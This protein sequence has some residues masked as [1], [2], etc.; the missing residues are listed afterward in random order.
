MFRVLRVDSD[1]TG[2]RCWVEEYQRAFSFAPSHFGAEQAIV[3]R[4]L[5]VYVVFTMRGA[6]LEPPQEP[7]ERRRPTLP[8][9]A[10]ER[11]RETSGER[12]RESKGAA[13]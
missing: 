11:Q 1:F 10:A 2:S 9:P 5:D 13:Q 8:G 3:G 4:T 6:W 12:Q 7:G